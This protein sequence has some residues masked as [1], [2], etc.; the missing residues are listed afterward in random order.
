MTVE[1][2]LGPASRDAQMHFTDK[3]LDLRLH[4]RLPA[5]RAEELEVHLAECAECSE[6]MANLAGALSRAD[7][8]SRLPAQQGERRSSLRVACDDPAQMQVLRPFSPNRLEARILNVSRG[9][10]KLRLKQAV[11]S[12]SLIQIRFKDSVVF[13]EVR[14]CARAG[15]EFEAGVHIHDLIPSRPPKLS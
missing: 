6:R 11:D 8:I 13:G 2:V 3:E 14:Y 4:D 9:G 12:G 1:Q 7:R 5:D 15:G 10:M